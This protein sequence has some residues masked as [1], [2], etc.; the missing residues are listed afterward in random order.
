MNFLNKCFDRFDLL[1]IRIGNL[2]LCGH[3]KN[4]ERER[5]RLMLVWVMGLGFENTCK[6]S[7]KSTVS[8]V[9]RRLYEWVYKT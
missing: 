6:V 9:I 5:E 4:E 8:R 3:Y 2:D 7:G 1:H